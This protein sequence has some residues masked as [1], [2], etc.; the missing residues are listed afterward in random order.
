MA[1]MGYGVWSLVAQQL[2]GS[3]V[4]GIVLWQASDWR[5]QWKFSR[6]HFHDLFAFGINLVGINILNFFVTRGDN[7]LIG[8]FLGSTALGYYDLAYR[9]LLVVTSLF[10]GV[11]SSIAMP[12]FSSIQDDLPR[13]RKVLYEF[14]ELTNTIAFPVF[15]GMS[16]LAPELIVVVFGE[17]WKPSIPVM[18]ILS[19]AGLLYGGFYFNAPLMMAMGKPNW[20]FYL[21]IYRTIIYVSAFLVGVKFG[22][23]GVSIAFVASAYLGSSWVTIIIIQKLIKINI[24]T[25]LSSFF[26]PL[27]NSI[28]M[29]VLIILVRYIIMIYQSSINPFLLCL[30]I[31]IGVLTYCV[32][33][34]NISNKLFSKFDKIRQQFLLKILS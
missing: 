16:V 9:L 13:L 27:V 7:L 24:L 29:I 30:Y 14:V 25:Y 15:L 31:V 17:Q 26:H 18:Q 8:Y 2:S 32:S 20:K 19:L 3:F 28:I 1:F 22:I 21:D 33:L 23:I 34:Y 6:K 4:G 5:P 10:V 12:I 11:I